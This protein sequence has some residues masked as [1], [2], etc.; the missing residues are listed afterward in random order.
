MRL[1]RAAERRGFVAD[2]RGGI[3]AL[4]D[5][6]RAWWLTGLDDRVKR[7]NRRTYGSWLYA[8][9]GF[10]GPVAPP[11]LPVSAEA[12]ARAAARL[13]R[14]APGAER[15]LC[16][17]TGS[18]SRWRE[19]RWKAEHYRAFIEA[20]ET[21]FPGAAVVVVGGP[22]ETAFNRELLAGTPGAVDGGTGNS[23]EEFAALVASCDWTLT[24]DSFGYHVACATGTPAACLVGPTAPWELD[25]YGRNLVVHS[26]VP[27][28]ACYRPACPLDRTCMDV[29]TPEVVWDE[30][31]R[32]RRDAGASDA[33]RVAAVAVEPVEPAG[34]ARL[35][36]ARG[37]G[38][39][40]A[41]APPGPAAFA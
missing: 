28:V 21:E 19:K 5:E 15:F 39:R 34:G 35:A 27:C 32:W 11:E 37:N 36:P 13:A 2:G 10:A 1:A 29:L 16:V 20:A 3:V 24:P 14:E 31:R 6:A 26:D 23:F 30:V 38:A 18:S 8:A 25:R 9:F 7:D 22:N 40:D 4:G 17:N 12:R 33:S 41:G